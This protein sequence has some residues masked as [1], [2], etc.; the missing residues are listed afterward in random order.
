MFINNYFVKMC[1]V[2]SILKTSYRSHVAGG[3]NKSEVPVSMQNACLYELA[4]TVAD[5]DADAP[6]MVQPSGSKPALG[7]SFGK[8][9]IQNYYHENIWT[10]KI[11]FQSKNR[12]SNKNRKKNVQRN[13][14]VRMTRTPFTVARQ[15][16]PSA[17]VHT[18]LQ[19]SKR[20]VGL[21]PAAGLLRPLFFM[22]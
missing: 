17:D 13:E 10:F 9:W 5:V 20:R 4:L 14:N 8:F 1:L 15:P 11:W 12:S 19:F 3:K 6:W 16:V 21:L 22:M 18:L 7:N 2:G